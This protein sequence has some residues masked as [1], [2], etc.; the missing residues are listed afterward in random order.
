MEKKQALVPESV[1]T[2][3][4][5][6]SEDFFNKIVEK[7]MHVP[8]VVIFQFPIIF[9]FSDFFLIVPLIKLSKMG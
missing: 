9:I 8:F 3:Q 4:K 2:K 7:K 6:S 5:C 1:V